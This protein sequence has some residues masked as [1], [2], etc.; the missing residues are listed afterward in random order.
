MKKLLILFILFSL[1]LSG[2]GLCNLN[3]FTLPDDTKFLAL[4]QE[5]D[6][7]RKICQ[8]MLDNFEY[9]LHLLRPLTPY[10][11]Y[12]LRKGDCDDFA[13][14]AIFISNYH[15][16]ETF[17]VK[18]HYKNCAINHCLAIYKENSLYNFS[19][20]QYYYSI[21]YDNFLDIVKLSNQWIYNSFGYIWSSYTVYDY[22]MNVIEQATR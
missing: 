1:L 16:Y 10:R 17:L 18:I 5:L 9:E 21:N 19:D 8:Y 13:N 12:L 3:Y 22:D 11:L 20:N 7:P 15:N 2:C 14:F 6:N 4:I